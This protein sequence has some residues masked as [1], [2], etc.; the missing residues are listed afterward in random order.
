MLPKPMSVISALLCGFERVINHGSASESQATHDSDTST[1]SDVPP[2]HHPEKARTWTSSRPTEDQFNTSRRRA[3]FPTHR[4]SSLSVISSI[5]DMVWS[6]TVDSFRSWFVRGVDPSVENSKLL[7][8]LAV[9]AW[10]EPQKKPKDWFSLASCRDLLDKHDIEAILKELKRSS[11]WKVDISH[12]TNYVR[13]AAPRLFMILAHTENMQLLEQFCSNGIKDDNF[14]LDAEIRK[15]K[16]VWKACTDQFPELLTLDS[17]QVGKVTSIFSLWQ[18]KF[19]VPHLTWGDFNC[20]ALPPESLLPFIGEGERVSSTAFSTVYKHTIHRDYVDNLPEALMTTSDL[21]RHP[22]VALKQLLPIGPVIDAFDSFVKAEYETLNMLRDFSTPHLI[23]ALAFYKKGKEFYFVFPWADCGNLR[24]FW[25]DKIPQPSEANYIK[26][27][28][29]QLLGLADAIRM[30]HESEG[31]NGGCRHG[32]IKPENILCFTSKGGRDHTSCVLVISDVG[33]SRTYDKTTQQRSVTRA[34]GGHTVAYA[35][36]ETELHGDR[37]TSRRYDIWSLGCLYLEF[38]IWL[39]YGYHGLHQFEEQ[40][41]QQTDRKFYR[42]ITDKKRLH[43]HGQKNKAEVNPVVRKWIER[44]KEYS[45]HAGTRLRETAVGRLITL[46][47]TRLLVVD[48]SPDPKDEELSQAPS[49]QQSSPTSTQEAGHA[50]KV[51]VRRPTLTDDRIPAAR[52]TGTTAER[53]SRLNERAYALEVYDE[54]RNIIEDAEAT[55]IKWNRQGDDGEQ[56][57]SRMETNSSLGNNLLPQ[58]GVSG[59]QDELDDKW[60]Y[61]PDTSMIERM[62]PT[63]T[64]WPPAFKPSQLCDRCQLL[65]LWSQ[66]CAFSDTRAQLEVT[67]KSCSFCKLLFTSLATWA[68]LPDEILQFFRT[69]SYLKFNNRQ[70]PPL[71]FFC[72]LP[73][74]ERSNQA[75]ES[76]MQYGFP[77]LPRPGSQKHCKLI[78]EWIRDCDDNH[79]CVDIEAEPF[80]PTRLLDVGSY[81]SRKSRLICET[82]GLDRKSKYLAMSHRWGVSIE[83]R[84]RVLRKSQIFCTRESNIHLLRAGV[85]DFDL[86]PKFQNGIHLARKLGIRYLW[87]DS[88]CIIQPDRSDPLDKDQGQDWAKE[89]DR[90]EKVFR[91]AYATIAASCANSSAEP[92]LVPRRGA[93]STILKTGKSI[94][95]ASEVMNRFYEDVEQ[96]EL[97]KRGWVFQERALSCRTIYFTKR[98]TYWECGEGIRCETLTR[99]KNTRASLL[100]D[101]NF[102]HEFPNYVKGK[103]IKLYQDLYERY[104]GLDLSYITDRPVAIRGLETRLLSALN[105]KGGYGVLDIFIRR[106]LLWQRKGESLPRIDFTKSEKKAQ[107]PVPSWSWTAHAGPIQYMDVPLGEVEWSEWEQDITSPWKHANNGEESTRELQVLVRDMTIMEPDRQVFLDNPSQTFDCPFKCV[108]VGS[109]KAPSYPKGRTY[110]ALIVTRADGRGEGYYERAGV[111]FLQNHQI[112]WGN[113]ALKAC[114]I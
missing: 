54:L 112:V 17:S 18:W 55:V 96:G 63:L 72:A 9:M 34:Q 113:L 14:P 37:P 56:Q 86:P 83:P 104:S 78:Q 102:P 36:P 103:Q 99:T 67:S 27:V 97:N 82:Q 46:I 77:N 51:I 106:G 31:K 8:N 95:Y 2:L 88:L 7:Q 3:T 110:Y 32:D 6:Y 22:Y 85:S 40:F 20:S 53:D 39:L 1:S 76:Q 61:V 11:K 38:L 105:S 29:R 26:W 16:A 111:A 68:V 89:A 58:G 92:F 44:I 15:D 52:A 87:I 19:F 108:I 49:D 24:A 30:L 12:L 66:E 21:G 74:D 98:Q 71:V 48:A 25:K 65:R 5:A 109:S 4:F 13:H 91:Y 69:N 47:E 35:A 93:P 28:F 79:K 101:A 23:K 73:K 57:L 45:Q 60:E 62:K 42:I 84:E 50:I 64:K 75:I 107:R 90:M 114:I 10:D 81:H 41:E 59:R 80:L 33:L 100:G 43:I 94:Y 70:L